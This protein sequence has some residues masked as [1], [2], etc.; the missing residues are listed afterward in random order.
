MEFEIEE[1]RS[2]M[3]DNCF[4]SLLSC[5]HLL[6]ALIEL[7]SVECDAGPQVLL[8]SRQSC[9]NGSICLIHPSKTPLR[10][11]TSPW[12]RITETLW[13]S[14]NPGPMTQHLLISGIIL[15]RYCSFVLGA[16]SRGEISFLIWSRFH[17]HH[18]CNA[19]LY[20]RIA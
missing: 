5:T 16:N 13:P 15:H 3:A 20:L 17:Q 14:S 12:K 18:I 9:D 4:C 6:V 1:M 7:E 19:G 8:L 2:K 10:P 11:K